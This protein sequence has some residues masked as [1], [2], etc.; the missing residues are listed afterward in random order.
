MI[1]IDYSV[2]WPSRHKGSSRYPPPHKKECVGGLL[3]SGKLHKSATIFT[4]FR[5]F[6]SSFRRQT[7]SCIIR[8]GHTRRIRK[9]KKK[10]AVGDFRA[11]ALACFPLTSKRKTA[12]SQSVYKL[13]Y[14]RT[15][16]TTV[17]TLED[18]QIV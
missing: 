9:K 1:K 14:S 8:A 11:R 10:H 12:R 5:L 7:V 4:I 3:F 13:N 6:F 18:E 17:L 2:A 15:S 16:L